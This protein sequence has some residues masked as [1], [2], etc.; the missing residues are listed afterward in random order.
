MKLI[1]R[2]N[3]LFPSAPSFFD[4]FVTKGVFDLSNGINN[5]NEL[6]IPAVNVKENENAF[7]VEVAAPGLQKNDF[8][9]ELEND[10]LTISS[11]KEID[12]ESNEG[13][14]TR[15]EFGY[16]SFKRTFSLPENIVDGGKVEAKYINGI[17]HIALPKKEEAKPKPVRAIE[18]G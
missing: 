4:D 3:G 14:Y 1:R 5:S 10:V 9:I 6:S 18:V 15:K 17:L 16:S 8:K 13:G 2:S 12:S 11:E 7:E